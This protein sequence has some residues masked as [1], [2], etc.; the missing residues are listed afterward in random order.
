MLDRPLRFCMIT[1]FY[2]P[3][4]FGGDGIFVHRLSNELARR[5]HRVS[6]I[7]CIDAYHLL[8]RGK[9]PAGDQNHPNVTVHGL[10][11]RF[12]FLSPLAT[13]QTGLPFF[14]SA[15]VRK[16][17]KEGFDVIHYHNISLVGGPKILEY[18]EGIKLYTMHDYWLVCPAHILFRFNQGP[19]EAPHCFL[20]TLT[21]KR[22]PQWWRYAR[23][24]QG[25][26]RHVDGF[27][28]PSQ[29]CKDIHRQRGLNIPIT[30]LPS[31]ASPTEAA[32]S[33][34]TSPFLQ[35][36]RE[37]YFL[38]VG[39]LEKLKGLQ[40]LIP[41]FSRYRK[42]QLLVLGTGGYEPHLRRLAEGIA[43]IHFL[44]Y[45]PEAQLQPLYRNAIALVVP[46]ICF[47]NLPLVILEAFRE[48]TPVIVRNL[49][50]MPE[51]VKESGGGLLYNSEEELIRAID[52]ML[53][54][55][56]LRRH[57]GLRGYHAYLRNWT[58]EAYLERY[59]RLI[60]EIQRK[61][62]K[63]ESH[64]SPLFPCSSSPSS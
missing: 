37:P 17:L 13:Q 30:H 39:R 53:T 8:A 63:N 59:F 15:H 25:A 11:S 38:F 31:F 57:L 33:A 50:G 58:V 4:N 42:A 21:H 28:A 44:G 46:S 6:V 43:N 61:K 29:F 54:D 26:I 9:P 36:P 22:L 5:G 27:I 56:S 12:S 62:S 40:T 7:H 18:G 41:V 45:L 19:C 1:T 49:G 64:P 20:C 16:I 10:K 32:P 51:P 35:G 52:L 23:L 3:Y 55:T 47:E 34:P 24:L 14:K 48:Q 2:P 60:S